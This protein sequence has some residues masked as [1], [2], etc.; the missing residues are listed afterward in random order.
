MLSIK[1]S[2]Y[3]WKDY[4]SAIILL[5]FTLNFNSDLNPSNLMIDN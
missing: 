1:I 4:S 3:W 5:V 2:S